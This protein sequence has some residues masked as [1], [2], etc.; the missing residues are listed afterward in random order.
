M[1]GHEGSA[2]VLTGWPVCNKGPDS[3]ADVPSAAVECTFEVRSWTVRGVEILDYGDYDTSDETAE[4]TCGHGSEDCAESIVLSE[5]DE[6]VDPHCVVDAPV[7]LS[8]H[9]LPGTIV[10][11]VT[12]RGVLIATIIYG[13]PR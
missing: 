11:E 7:P 1:S 6:T 9:E 5:D 4:K 8:C 13:G 2:T 12:V 10:A 3:S